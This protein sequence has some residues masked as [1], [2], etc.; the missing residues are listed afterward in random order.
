MSDPQKLLFVDSDT[1]V[2][3]LLTVGFRAAGYQTYQASSWS[4]G[5]AIFEKEN[6]HLVICESHFSEKQDFSFLQKVRECSKIPVMILAGD[7]REL[8]RIRAFQ[9]GAD[10]F[11]GK[12]FSVEETVLRGQRLLYYYYKHHQ[13][14]IFNHTYQYPFIS[15]NETTEEVI[16]HEKKLVLTHLEYQLLLYFIKRPNVTF[17]RAHLLHE[18]WNYT[19]FGEERTVD[20]HIK[21][22]R[23]KLRRYSVQAALSIETVRGTGYRFNSNV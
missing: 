5:M 21:R 3:D 6:I 15:V 13:G 23:G 20:T 18:V 8:Q 17:S 9:Q 12:P 16:I 19:Y 7:D 11:I 10:D 22:L 14:I 2:L 4:K 1:R